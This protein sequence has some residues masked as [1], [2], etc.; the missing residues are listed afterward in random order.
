MRRR[1]RRRR[2]R[3]EENGFGSGWRE[4]GRSLSLAGNDILLSSLFLSLLP[5]SLSSLFVLSSDLLVA[6]RRRREEG[7]YDTPGQEAE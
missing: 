2:K 4:G 7:L 1:R 6:L 5:L 3:E